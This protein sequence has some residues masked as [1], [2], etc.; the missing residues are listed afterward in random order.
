MK[1]YADART[2][3]KTIEDNP[4]KASGKAQIRITSPNLCS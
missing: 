3:D 4:Q 1:I 2:V